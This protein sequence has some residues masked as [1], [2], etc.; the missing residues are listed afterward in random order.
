MSKLRYTDEFK[1]QAL[2]H[3]DQVGVTRASKDLGVS[4]SNIYNWRSLFKIA[5]SLPLKTVSSTELDELKSLRRE[6]SELKKVNHILKSA[7][8]FFSQ[9]HLK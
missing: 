9:D 4:D 8:A 6:N 1:K 5:G 2:E 7:A 3:A